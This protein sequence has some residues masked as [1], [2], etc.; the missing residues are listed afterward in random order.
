MLSQR[1]CKECGKIFIPKSSRRLYCYDDHYRVCDG[2]GKLFLCTNQQLASNKHSCSKE[3]MI[4]VREATRKRLDR[5]YTCNCKYCNHSFDGNSKQDSVCRRDHYAVCRYCGVLFKLSHEE[6]VRGKIT[7]SHECKVKYS[8][9]QL[10]IFGK[11]NHEK[12]K[13]TMIERYGVDNPMKSK[14]FQRKS[15]ETSLKKYGETS[16]TKTNMFR[17]RCISTNRRKYGVDWESQTNKHK[18][19]VVNTSMKKYGVSN[20]AMSR[21]VIEDRM[22]DPTKID[23]LLSFRSD[24]KHFIYTNFE[25]TPTLSQVA[26]ICGIRDSSVGW[27]L[28]NA[29][30]MDMVKFS[31]SKMEDELFDFLSQH[32][33]SSSIV[34]NTRK[35]IAPYELDLYLPK[36]RFAIEC[37]PTSTHNSSKGIFPVNDGP[38]SKIYHKLKTDMCEDIGIQLFHVFGYDWTYHKDC[39]KSMLLYNLGLIEDRVYARNLD[40]RDVPGKEAFEFLEDNHRQGGV[41]CKIRIGLYQGSDLLSL[42]TFSNMRNTIGTD[43]SNLSDCYELVRFCSKINKVVVGG[44]GK[45]FSHF[46]KTY[47]PERIRSFSDRAHTKGSLYPNLGFKEIRRSDPGYVWVDTKTD[48]SYSRVNAQKHNIK[49]FLKDDSID[50]SNTEEGIMVEHG[51]VQV[52]D[53]GTITWEWSNSRR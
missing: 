18:Q 9:K 36:Y 46:I 21:Y 51:F 44:A 15:Q 20:P 41:H 49:S 10:I 47:E 2:C 19:A 1:I 42:M 13:L 17:E 26:D 23:M 43:S 33:D 28:S 40:I 53:S 12:T 25:T 5:K 48:K 3:C 7:C 39:I 32:V 11:D 6:A 27:I 35:V 30:L 29:N 38:K 24:P 45:L 8:Q 34:R 31:Y 22:L 4:K 37:N 50:L 52:F 14:I 16:F